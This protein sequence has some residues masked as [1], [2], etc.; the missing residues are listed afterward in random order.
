MLK[1]KKYLKDVTGQKCQ[2]IG[3]VNKEGNVNIP[4]IF[5]MPHPFNLATL[6]RRTSIFIIFSMSVVCA[7]LV[8][9]ASYI[10]TISGNRLF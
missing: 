3:N 4:D 7:E 1:Q 5:V 9:F 6:F 8:K 10:E 2:I